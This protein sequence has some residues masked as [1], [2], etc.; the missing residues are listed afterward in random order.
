M[1]MKRE[2][3]RFL[4]KLDEIDLDSIDYN[5]EDKMES[6]LDCIKRVERRSKRYW[7][8]FI[9]ITEFNSHLIYSKRPYYLI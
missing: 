5:S 4:T 3:D 1:L 2:I 6:H 7:V 9:C 8:P